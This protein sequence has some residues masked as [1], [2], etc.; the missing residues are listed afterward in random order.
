MKLGQRLLLA[1]RVISLP[2]GTLSGHSGLRQPAAQQVYEFTARLPTTATAAV[3]P[4][5]PSRAT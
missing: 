5:F 2:C 3:W 4:V 1:H